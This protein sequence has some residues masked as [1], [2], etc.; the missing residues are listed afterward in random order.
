MHPEDPQQLFTIRLQF[1]T[2]QNRNPKYA[3]IA[4]EASQLYKRKKHKRQYCISYSGIELKKTHL[5]VDINR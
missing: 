4:N 3:C 5:S 1:A 2:P